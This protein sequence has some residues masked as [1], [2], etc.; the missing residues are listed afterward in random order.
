MRMNPSRN[1]NLN[2]KGG[3]VGVLDIY[4]LNIP[5][6]VKDIKR[7][8]IKETTTEVCLELKE[9]SSISSNSSGCF[10][11]FQPWQWPTNWCFNLNPKCSRMNSNLDAWRHALEGFVVVVATAAV[12]VAKQV[13]QVSTCHKKRWRNKPWRKRWLTIATWRLKWGCLLLTIIFETNEWIPQNH[14][15]WKRWLRL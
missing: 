8:R 3:S 7:L 6:T 9:P 4:R 12:V 2:Q 11:L 15:S 1:A 13:K 10:M 5:A 14:G